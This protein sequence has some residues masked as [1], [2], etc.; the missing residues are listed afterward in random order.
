MQEEHPICESFKSIQGESTYAG[1]PC[2]FIRYYGCN[3]RCSYCDT[4]FAWDEN[5]SYEMIT[6]KALVSLV[7]ESGLSLVELT[8]GE[9]LIH[10]EKVA[11]LSQALLGEGMTVLIETNGS[12]PIE[13]LPQNVIKIMDIKTPSSEMSHLNLWSN[14]L[15]L[16]SLDEVK[17]VIAHEDDFHYALEVIKKY[18]LNEKIHAVLFSPNTKLI[19]PQKLAE[20]ILKTPI[21][22]I[23][24]QLQQHKY[25]WPSTLRGV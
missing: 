14:M 17:F 1:L 3:L 22:G 23:R 13:V 24:L 2:F 6:T 10:A 15:H 9:P 4:S 12:Q 18:H 8:G 25:I 21:K 5:A 16:C 11:K 7:K 19:S 20:W